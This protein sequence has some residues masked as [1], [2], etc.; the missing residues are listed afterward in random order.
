MVDCLQFLDE[1][2]LG[3]LYVTEGDGALT[4]IAVGYLRVENSVDKVANGNGGAG[5]MF[6]AVGWL[7]GY[8]KVFKVFH[9]FTC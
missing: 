4:E 9:V 1:Y 3:I 2:R 8:V 7:E 5:E 6:F